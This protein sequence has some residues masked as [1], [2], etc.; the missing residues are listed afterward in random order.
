VR[1]LS[2][3][4][5]LDKRHDDIFRGHE[6]QFLRDPPPNDLRVHHQTLRHVLQRREHYVRS[7]ERLWQRH[8]PIRAV[9]QRALEPLY[10]RR[11][12]RV[13]VQRHKVSRKRADALRP[14]RV[15]LVSH[16]RGTD[17]R[18]FEWLLHFLRA[19]CVFVISFITSEGGRE[20]YLETS[21]EA[22]VSGDFVGCRAE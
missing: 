11:P 14:H 10:A 9:V 17:L 4:T 12:E 5:L 6:R 13:L 18:R 15:P 16:R 22:Q 8:S 19:T 2:I 21:K 20:R 7:E 3:T 1:F